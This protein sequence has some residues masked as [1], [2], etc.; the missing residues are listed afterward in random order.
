[1]CPWQPYSRRR[2]DR[3]ADC[4]SRNAPRRLFL[5]GT[6]RTY[7]H[8][9]DGMQGESGLG[10]HKTLRLL[11]IAAVFQLILYVIVIGKAQ[12]EAYLGVEAAQ[13]VKTAYNSLASHA[14]CDFPLAEGELRGG[15]DVR[16]FSGEFLQGVLS[17]QQS[18]RDGVMVQPELAHEHGF[19]VFETD[20]HM[21]SS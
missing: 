1:M 6:Q 18:D 8:A 20:I 14:R 2:G 19:H 4:R 17:R 13:P 10:G 15:D 5:G 3:P 21:W 16:I 12:A 11:F 7:G 9:D